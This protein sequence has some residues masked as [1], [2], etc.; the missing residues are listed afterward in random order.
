MSRINRA[1]HEGHRM[2]KNPTELQRIAWHAE[3]MRNCGCRGIDPGVAKLFE[4]HGVT[5]PLSNPGPSGSGD[6]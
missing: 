3:H 5:V 2:P 1:W 4:K 6:R